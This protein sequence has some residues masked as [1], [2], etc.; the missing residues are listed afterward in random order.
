MFYD[1]L[2]VRKCTKKLDCRVISVEH[3]SK[4]IEVTLKK[5]G[6]SNA[7]KS[8]NS[9]LSRLHVGEIISGRIKRVESYGLFIALDHTNLVIT[10]PFQNFFYGGPI[11]GFKLS[12]FEGYL[13]LYHACV[14]W[15]LF[16]F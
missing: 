6:V 8:E 1:G 12:L 3:L 4:R 10:N 15:F 5:S 14:C 7:S 13:Q 9:D 2:H 11:N 16:C